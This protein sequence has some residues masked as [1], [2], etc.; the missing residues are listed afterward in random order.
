[1]SVASRTTSEH[2][3]P[4]A[5]ILII[6]VG[7]IGG[8]IAA[9]CK[10][11]PEGQRPY[12]RGIDIDS[13]AV[14]TAVEQA[15][16]DEGAIPSDARTDSWLSTTADD[17]IVLATPAREAKA[18]F[19]RI[20]GAGHRGVLT[21][22]ASTKAALTALADGI[23]SCPQRYIPG[24]PMAGSE[25]N[26]IEGARATLFQNAHWILCPDAHSEPAAFTRLHELITSLGARGISLPREEHDDAMA[27]VSHVPHMVA[28]ALVQLAGTH[29]VERQEIFRLAAGGFKDTTRIAAGSPELWSGIALD[30]REALARGL[31]EVGRIIKGF[32]QALAQGDSRG[33]TALLAEAARLRRSIPATWVPD[34]DRLVEVRIPMANRAGVI[35]QVTGFAGKAGCNIQSIDID[36]IN[37]ATAILEL[38]LTDEGDLGSF[39]S[40]LIGDGF[41]VSLRPLAPAGS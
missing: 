22:V 4:F 40:Q 19:E 9:A 28:S 1:M 18:W 6:G 13:R 41:D 21:D 5:S 20:E 3:R 15:F 38:I 12:I 7:L 37:E 39:T 26:G 32:E 25:V 23:L 10:A 11:L 24:H 17:L 36:H 29:A 14:K 31:A 33:L 34:S 30:N 8:S 27:I 16:L 35:A 2:N